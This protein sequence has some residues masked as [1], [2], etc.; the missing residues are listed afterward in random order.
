MY[1]ATL[2]V[3]SSTIPNSVTH[4][5]GLTTRM[6]FDPIDSEGSRL[7]VMNTVTVPSSLEMFRIPCLGGSSPISFK[8]RWYR[9][10]SSRYDSTDSLSGNGGIFLYATAD[11]GPLSSLVR[12]STELISPTPRTPTLTFPL[13]SSIR[14]LL[15]RLNIRTSLSRYL[16][17][18]S[19]S[20]KNSTAR[21][22]Y[23]SSTPTVRGSFPANVRSMGR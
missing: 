8:T 17:R 14:S 10:N 11:I 4:S 20:L 9:L 5:S 23:S 13:K 7:W 21:S 2:R 16:R 3:S 22:R 19:I 1:S 6:T 18:S 12:A 15:K